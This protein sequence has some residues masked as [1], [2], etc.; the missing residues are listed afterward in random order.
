VT[1]SGS[2]PATGV[3]IDVQYA[4][5]LQ[6][7][8]ASGAGRTDDLPRRTATWR[9]AEIAGGQTVRKQLN[10]RCASPD[11]SGA[12]VR[13]TATADRLTDTPTG[14]A[15]T[16]IARGAGVAPPPVVPEG[17]SLKVTVS[18]LADPIM[19]GGKTT[20]VVTLTIE[21]T[22]AD[23][24]VAITLEASAGLELVGSSGPTALAS[25]SQDGRSAD[26][27]PITELAAGEK[28]VYRITA[29]GR[30]AGKQQ[31]RVTVKSKLAPA[32]ITAEGET[33]VNM[34]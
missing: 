31:L 25:R 16:I 22:V 18:D 24:D 10:C 11:E 3:V 17:G 13:A 1:N 34:P 27:T 32:G 28:V 33:T 19:I 21:R 23:Q 20:Y 30:Q 29:T 4:A 8:R 15:R 14:E 9:V 5:S 6:F 12:V 7:D 26:V 2:S